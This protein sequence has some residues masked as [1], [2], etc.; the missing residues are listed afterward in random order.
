MEGGLQLHKVKSLSKKA[1][2]QGT[3][4]KGDGNLPYQEP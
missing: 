1:V 4:R 3:K 2:V